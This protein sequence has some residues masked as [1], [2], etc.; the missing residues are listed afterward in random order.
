MTT[1]SFVI[2]LRPAPLY[3]TE[4]SKEKVSEHFEY[5]KGLKSEGKLIMA[6]RFSEML[7][8]LVI[9]ETKSKDEALE[10]MRNDPAVLAE[11]FHGE[12]YPWT[13]A[14]SKLDSV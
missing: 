3:G 12:L 13:I 9:I 10:I 5:L 8:G 2:M 7:I 11:I 6:G 1:E 4:G 14:L